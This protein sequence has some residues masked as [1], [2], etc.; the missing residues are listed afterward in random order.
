MSGTLKLT[1]RNPTSEDNDWQAIV[2]VLIKSSSE[3]Y[4]DWLRLRVSS[5]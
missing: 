3:K 5:N 1:L 4:I 2:T